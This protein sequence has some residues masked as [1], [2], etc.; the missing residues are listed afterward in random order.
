MSNPIHH[1]KL[2]IL[3]VDDDPDTRD[4]VSMMFSDTGHKLLTIGQG[5]AALELLEHQKFDVILLD[6]MMPD[7]DGLMVLENIRKKSSA[8][9]LMLTALSN[10]QIMEQSY[11]LGA[12]DYIVKPFSKNKLLER[13]DRLAR[14]LTSFVDDSL[15]GWKADFAIDYE[16]NELVYHGRTIEMTPTELRLLTRLM[17]SAFVD[18]N[19]MDLYEAGWGRE[20]L[21]F[22]TRQALVE[23]TI[24]SLREKLETDPQNPKLLLSAEN[25]WILRPG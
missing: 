19:V 11:Q 14:Q 25:G 6:I 4:L 7:F 10:V 22:R 18:V 9:V 8:P 12:N 1:P 13:I 15:A 20:P 21:P 24:R 23:N 16:K 17:E 2:K 5:Q 3:L